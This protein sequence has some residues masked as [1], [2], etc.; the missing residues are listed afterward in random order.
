MRRVM[1]SWIHWMGK[2]WSIGFHEYGNC[3]YF[4][5]SK[6]EYSTCTFYSFWRFFLSID[7]K[8]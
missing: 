5:Y 8:S 2:G 6:T 4:K 1:K 3:W 7:K